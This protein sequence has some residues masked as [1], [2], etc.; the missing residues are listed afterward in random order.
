MSPLDLPEGSI[1]F[2]DELPITLRRQ[3]ILRTIR[4]HQVVVVAG[5]T[6]SGKSTQLP[7]MCLELGRGA[8]GF[9]GHT[10]P[11]RIAAR[12]IAERVADE[13]SN[14]EAFGVGVGGL[15]GYQV[16]F[17]DVVGPHT[18]LKLMTD[19]ILLAEIQHDPML[20]RYDTLIIDEAHERSLNIDFLLGWL[21]QLLPKRSDLKLIIT[22]ATIDT[23]RFAR[24]F[25]SAD[26]SPA[27]IIEVSGRTYPVDVRYEPIE[28]GDQ[29]DAIC[30]AV[31]QLL[32]EV[33]GDVLVFCSGEREIR[34]ATEALT[35]MAL[36]DTEVVPLF[37][38]LSAAEQHRVF[39][40]H[41]GRR[42]VV[43]TNVAETSL[44][45][46]GIRSVVDPGTARISRFNRRTK[47]QR[48]PIEPI[49]QASADQRAGRCGR[50]GPGVCVRLYTQDDLAGRPEFTEPEIQRTNLASVI[51]QMATLG[52]G[53]VEAF[54]FV[55]PPD[56]A[57]IRDGVALLEEL[58][59]VRPGRQ[60]ERNWVTK[61]GRTLAR[62][63]LD[64]RLGRMLIEAERLGCLHEVRII[65]AGLSIQDPRERPRGQ[66][67]AA[68]EAHARFNDET[69]DFLSWLHLWDY[70]ES[71]RRERSSNQF[72][73]MC[74]S[75]FLNAQRVRE[76][77]DLHS[78]LRR[79]VRD[80]NARPSGAPATHPDIIHRA[81]L[82][83]LLSHIGRKDPD[84]SDYRGP[85]GTRFAIAPGSGLFKR[86]P[87]WIMA[88]ELVETNRMWARGIGRLQP[89]WLERV[90]AHL[91][92]HSYGDPWWDVDQAVAKV[93][94]SATIY[95]LPV[96]TNRT[97]LLHRT[98]AQGARWLML[99][100]AFVLGE[101][102]PRQPPFS[103]R[104]AERRDEVIALEIKARRDDL[105]RTHEELVEWFEQRLPEHII[106][107]KEFDRWWRDIRRS[108]PERFDLTI[109][110]LSHPVASELE[111][112][113]FPDELREGDAA[114]PL[115][116]V[117][118]PGHRLDGVTIDVPLDQLN[119]VDAAAFDWLI[120]GMRDD[121]VEGLLRTLPKP[122]RKQLLPMAETARTLASSLEGHSSEI[123]SAL[124]GELRRSRGV[125]VDAGSFDLDKLPS[126]LR[127]RFRIVDDAEVAEP[128]VLA[129][130][131]NLDDLRMLLD[132]HV[133]H[134][135]ARA[136]HDLER[137]DLTTWDIGELPRSVEVQHGGHRV[138]A[139]PSLVAEDDRVALRLLPTSE[140]Q[141]EAMWTGTRRLLGLHRPSLSK[142][143]RPLLTTRTKLALIQGPYASPAEWLDD[144]V[145]AAIEEVLVAAG[146]P[147]WTQ[148]AFDDLATRVR[149][150]LPTLV[151][152]IA[153]RSLDVLHAHG[154][155]VA[156][157][158][159]M[160]D[161]HLS[162]TRD[163]LEQ[164]DRLVYPGFLTALETERLDDL[165][166]Y[167]RAATYRVERIT[168]HATRDAD[169][170]ARVRRLEADWAGLVAASGWTP[171]LEDAA[172]MLQ[173]LR[174]GLFAQH[175][176]TKQTVSEKRIR[177]LLARLA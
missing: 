62:L 142:I 28:D 90:G 160:A 93:H 141:Q 60:G 113:A 101:W 41:R 59:A 138:T 87:S 119:T 82:S 80:R 84:G 167:L 86:N 9:I 152:D 52:L 158:S 111:A 131:D 43:A 37:A 128:N 11:R 70:L 51:L 4:D 91:L 21:H 170:M 174:V 177:N 130:G 163:V 39:A 85:R 121:L 68:R 153:E 124:A 149:R 63:P 136:G 58:G 116:Y 106:T 143:L 97:E 67:Q 57:A 154:E 54:P 29:T 49:S 42:V 40:S 26:G 15:V 75:E 171:A 117:Y 161:S 5:E 64:P 165:S 55:D 12:S 74:R 150:E 47:V 13:L 19:G 127:P 109:A 18:R 89:E 172:W 61:L 16:R 32:G 123:T 76:W 8:N 173:E 105:L 168:Q 45:V 71:A 20:R 134:T 50:L 112:D 22:S 125:D 176:G 135:V 151:A 65:V 92:V 30:D 132:Q 148:D 14:L 137:T 72:R 81:L 139:Y 147:A 155:L 144:C 33:P 146:G 35:E 159:D 107:V 103:D 110:D 66:E 17:T 2:P 34:D 27:P 10:Q 38:R 6:G 1:R 7:K 162:V 140:E 44:T 175:L 56:R 157:L 100:H 126:H 108:E 102:G 118:E 169:L 164:R 95:G 133:R 46:P 31:S 166:R 115:T 104:N 88:A 120:P 79:I 24:H 25:A 122:L 73:R 145:G 48:L 77:Q 98:D 53:D 83:G 69:S 114:L 129:E 96:F 36:P 94:H 23:E 78:Q 156:A 3:E 99:S